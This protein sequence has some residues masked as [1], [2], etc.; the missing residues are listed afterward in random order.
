MMSYKKALEEMGI[1]RERNILRLQQLT[2]ELDPNDPD[3]DDDINIIY[4][5]IQ[6]TVFIHKYPEEPLLFVLY[7]IS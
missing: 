4:I 1:L 5:S 2:K 7:I 6:I 3:H